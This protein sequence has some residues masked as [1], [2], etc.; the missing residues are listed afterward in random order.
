MH[1]MVDILMP[2]CGIRDVLFRFFSNTILF[3]IHNQR[4]SHLVGMYPLITLD[5][6]I[7]N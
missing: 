4:R 5:E 2:R 6:E 7:L 1:L 3:I